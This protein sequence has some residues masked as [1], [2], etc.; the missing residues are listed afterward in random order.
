MTARSEALPKHRRR[1]RP[2]IAS[3]DKTSAEGRG[4][5]PGRLR[6]R[7]TPLS[8]PRPDQLA[9]VTVVVVDDDEGSLDYF[10]MALRTY[11]AVVLTAS[12]AVDALQLVRE[13]RPDAVLSDIA[14]ADHDGYWLVREIRGD[15]ALQRIPVIATTAYGREHSRQRTLEAGFTEHL[16]KPVDPAILTVTIAKVTGRS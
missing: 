14:M 6:T 7:P 5:V 1:P 12:N 2:L 9:G 8:P 10:A 13:R 11:G 4:P 3:G 16:A 15:A